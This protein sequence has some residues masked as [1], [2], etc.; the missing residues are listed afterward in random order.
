M[1]VLHSTECS[2]HSFAGQVSFASEGFSS[3][4]AL[5]IC[6]RQRFTLL[7]HAIHSCSV[8]APINTIERQ[9]LLENVRMLYDML[10]ASEIIL[11]TPMPQSFT[12]WAFF[13]IAAFLTKMHVK[14]YN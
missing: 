12:R 9:M 8:Q 7:L 3:V 11:Q 5:V 6:I 10:G 4:P 2:L 13:C 14:T 1:L